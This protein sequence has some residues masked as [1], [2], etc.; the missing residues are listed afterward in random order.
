MAYAKNGD[1]QEASTTLKRALS[2]KL[3]GADAV[4]AKKMLEE[5]SI[6]GAL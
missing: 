5:L 2:L 3:D 4:E 6:L 1:D